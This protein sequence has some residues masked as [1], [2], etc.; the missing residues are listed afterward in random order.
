M[1]SNLDTSAQP[2]DETREASDDR[3]RFWWV[4]ACLTP[5]L[6]A[7]L[8]LAAVPVVDGPAALSGLSGMLLALCLGAAV[9]TDLGSRRIRNWT[10]Y[11]TI[12][13]ALLVNCVQSLL[14]WNGASEVARQVGG[15]G[16]IPSLL[17]TLIC[18]SGMF[19]LFLVFEGGA[20]DVKFVAALGALVGWYDGF[21]IWLC[22]M[23]LAGLFALCYSVLSAMARS[24]WFRAKPWLGLQI[25]LHGLLL[26]SEVSPELKA[27]L[28]QRIPLAPFFTVG[29]IV[30]LGVEWSQPGTSF[31]NEFLS[32]L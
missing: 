6:A 2:G 25:V 3:S 1:S 23:L 29:T 22:S 20:G 7:P 19:A 10:C 4:V 32:V 31:L 8:W 18:F 28:K 11:P 12:A 16:F 27:G 5:C 14:Q 26:K 9:V 13:F 15:I 24:A 30:V 17:G 21:Q